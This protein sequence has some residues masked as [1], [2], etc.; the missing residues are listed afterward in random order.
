MRSLLSGRLADFLWGLRLPRAEG[1][2]G[3]G[4]CFAQPNDR[5][6]QQDPHRAQG[7]APRA[8]R[9]S[10]LPHALTEGEPDRWQQRDHR[11]DGAIQRN[12]TAVQRALTR[13]QAIYPAKRFPDPRRRDP[14][15]VMEP[16]SLQKRHTIRACV[17]G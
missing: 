5:S 1:D 7:I 4:A 3:S 11:Q 6:Q 8:V 14:T 2:I 9:R 13:W 10:R 17:T 15:R 12:Q 16:F